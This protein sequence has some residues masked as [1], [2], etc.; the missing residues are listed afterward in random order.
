MAFYLFNFSLRG[1]EACFIEGFLTKNVKENFKI[2][3]LLQTKVSV[4]G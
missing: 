1:G 4:Q 3:H 2:L